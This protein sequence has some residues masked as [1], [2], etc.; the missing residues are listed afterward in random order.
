M[1]IEEEKDKTLQGIG[2]PEK[3]KGDLASCYSRRINQEHRLIYSY[4]SSYKVE[5]ISC[6]GHYT[7]K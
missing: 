6:Y 5:L 2:K 1:S 3:L 4:S 7:D